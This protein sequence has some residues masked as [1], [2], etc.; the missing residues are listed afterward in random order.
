MRGED[1]LS[2]SLFSYVDLESRVPG[3]HPLWRI[4]EVVNQV[5]AAYNLIRLPKLLAA[6]R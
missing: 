4:R 5:L 1:R 6:P 2:G 3:T